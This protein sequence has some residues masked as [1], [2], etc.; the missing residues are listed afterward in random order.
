MS[1]PLSISLPVDQKSNGEPSPD[2][3]PFTPESLSNLFENPKTCQQSIPTKWWVS[4][5]LWKKKFS[6][7]FKYLPIRLFLVL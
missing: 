7:E 4:L 5:P 3:L 1:Y 2:I 6:N